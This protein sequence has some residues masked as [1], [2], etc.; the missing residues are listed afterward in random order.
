MKYV[1]TVAD[2][3]PYLDIDSLKIQKEEAST[4]LSGSENSSISNFKSTIL[5]HTALIFKEQ[6]KVKDTGSRENGI[7]QPHYSIQRIDG[8]DILCYKVNKQDLHSSI[9]EAD[10]EEYCP[11]T[12]NI[13]FIRNRQ[14]QKRLSG[15]P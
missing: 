6:R 9:I 3:L 10:D 7:A 11:V 13:N 5:I 14:E 12:M 4:L 1:V 8:Y 15:I 2:S